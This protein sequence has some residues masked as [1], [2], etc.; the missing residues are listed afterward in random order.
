MLDMFRQ[1][2]PVVETLN[3]LYD[4]VISQGVADAEHKGCILVNAATELAH[5]DGAVAEIVNSNRAEIEQAMAAAFAKA[6]ARGEIADGFP[7][8]AL[9]QFFFS[10]IGGLQLPVRSQADLATLN[11][12]KSV[13]LAVLQTPETKQQK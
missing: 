7:P 11:N 5:E 8:P 3:C 6:Q 12:V 13:A 4:S 1:D 2:R 10:S 9:A